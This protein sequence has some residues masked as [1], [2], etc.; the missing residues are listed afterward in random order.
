MNRCKVGI[1]R[2]TEIT[3]AVLPTKFELDTSVQHFTT[4]SLYCCKSQL[5]S[6][7]HIMKLISGTLV[8]EYGS[9]RQSVFQET[10]IDTQVGLL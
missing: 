6:N 5:R 9:K 1:D 8:I 2:V 4:V 3:D 10:S 7:I